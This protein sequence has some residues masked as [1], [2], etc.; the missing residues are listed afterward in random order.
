LGGEE[1]SRLSSLKL[2][3]GDGL[4]AFGKK[5]KSQLAREKSPRLQKKKKIWGG[6]RG[7]CSRGGQPGGKCPAK[8]GDAKRPTCK[9]K[10]KGVS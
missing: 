6:R 5:K 9:K 3:K 10:K 4:T 2:G 7:L 8:K 1:E